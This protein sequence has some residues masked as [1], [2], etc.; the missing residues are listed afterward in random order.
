MHFPV[1]ENRAKKRTGSVGARSF[2][3][4]KFDV[5]QKL[6]WGKSYAAVELRE[7]LPAIVRIFPFSAT[8]PTGTVPA[9]VPGPFIRV[10]EGNN[11]IVSLQHMRR[12]TGTILLSPSQEP[13]CRYCKAPEEDELADVLLLTL[14]PLFGE[15]DRRRPRSLCR[16]H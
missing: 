5:D 7:R 10:R 12:L 3:V 11:V 6:I 9:K 4:T 1:C 15:S 13:I 8:L 14:D 16:S 2:M